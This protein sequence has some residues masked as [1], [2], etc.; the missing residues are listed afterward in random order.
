MWAQLGNALLGIWLMAAPAVLHYAG[1]ASV[2]DRIVG[3]LAAACAIIALSEVTR[4]VRWVNV[5]LG[6][7]LIVAPWIWGAPYR[8]AVNDVVVGLLLAL[9]ALV[10]G[11]HTQRV[12]GG[13]ASLWQATPPQAEAAQPVRRHDVRQGNQKG[14]RR[15]GAKSAIGGESCSFLPRVLLHCQHWQ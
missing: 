15:N 8:G 2:N 13:W 10:R 14:S 9:C 11:T 3:P 4:P 1:A 5:A 6:L 12:G 7:W